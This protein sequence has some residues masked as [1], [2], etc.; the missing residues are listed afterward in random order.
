MKRGKTFLLHV[1]GKWRTHTIAGTFEGN[2]KSI[3]SGWS[4]GQNA[5]MSRRLPRTDVTLGIFRKGNDE[6]DS[7][8]KHWRGGT[9]QEFYL[10]HTPNGAGKKSGLA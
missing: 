3:E 9:V 4:R 8:L 10:R 1:P 6:R 2:D 7:S 5:N